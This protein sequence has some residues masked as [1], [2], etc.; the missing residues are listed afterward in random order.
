VTPRPQMTHRPVHTDALD[1]QDKTPQSMLSTWILGLLFALVISWLP[2][3]SE[4][5]PMPTET[6]LAVERHCPLPMA[7]N[8]VCA[9]P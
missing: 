4:T 6:R 7:D 5:T 8:S 2:A 9:A 1:D 3:A